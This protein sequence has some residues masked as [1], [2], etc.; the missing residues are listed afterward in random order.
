MDSSASVFQERI[1][2]G[3]FVENMI[4]SA[5]S[6]F[7][8][9]V[10]SHNQQL[11]AECVDCVECADVQEGR[12]GVQIELELANKGEVPSD[13][14]LAEILADKLQNSIN[15]LNDVLDRANE[16]KDTWHEEKHLE[17]ERVWENIQL[18]GYW[19]FA[20]STGLLTITISINTEA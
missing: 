3:K 4:E 6:T 14:A 13:E 20:S 9:K 18:G 17:G 2:I 5:Q 10:K 12:H 1:L 16:R 8:S 11:S 19:K 15:N 7:N